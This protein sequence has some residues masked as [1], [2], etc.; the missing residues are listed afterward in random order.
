MQAAPAIKGEYVAVDPVAAR[1]AAEDY[2]AASDVTGT[3]TITGGDTITVNVTD[4][5]TPK[6][7]GPHRHPRPDRHRHGFG[8]TDS[9]PRR[10]EQ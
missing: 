7:L 9:Q 4:T 3:V 2:L 8:T 5:Y 1:T 10:D 6:F